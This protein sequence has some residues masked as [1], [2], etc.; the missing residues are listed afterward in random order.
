MPYKKTNKNKNTL[1]KIK[2]KK[3]SRSYYTKKR[4]KK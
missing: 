3:Q 2:P 1:N 4:G